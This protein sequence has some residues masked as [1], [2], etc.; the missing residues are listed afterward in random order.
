[1]LF[2][3]IRVTI[4]SI[5]QFNFHERFL[6]RSGRDYCLC[7]LSHSSRFIFLHFSASRRDMPTVASN[8]VGN[9]FDL[10]MAWVIL[11]EN[12]A[13]WKSRIATVKLIYGIVVLRERELRRW[14]KLLSQ[15]TGSKV[16]SQL[17]I[18]A[19]LSGAQ[20]PFIKLIV[21]QN[22]QRLETTCSE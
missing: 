21:Q 15:V 18:L 1:M 17:R 22:N 19:F 12:W 5:S 9:P 7:I 6:I 10:L 11:V 16:L 3:Y 8:R 2:Q 13:K 4:S 20:F 14:I